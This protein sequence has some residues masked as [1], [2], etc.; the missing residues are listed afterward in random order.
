MD[1]SVER[2]YSKGDE[3]VADAARASFD[4]TADGYTPEQNARLLNFLAKAEPPHWTP[5]GH[6]RITIDMPKR[7]LNHE[8]ILENETL[9]AGLAIER[10]SNTD[11]RVTHSV[12]G[13]ANMVRNN[14]LGDHTQKVTDRLNS[15]KGLNQTLEVLGLRR[16]PELASGASYS[17]DDISLRIRCPIV[18]ARQLFKHQVGFV[19][20]EASGRYITYSTINRPWTWK[21]APDNKKQ[22]AGEPV[23]FLRHMAAEA[24]TSFAYGVSR[25]AYWFLRRGLGIA[26]E[27]AR[28]VMPLATD[29]TFVVTA[30]R[31]GWQR[32]LDH[33]L[34]SAAQS[35]IQYLAYAIGDEIH[36]FR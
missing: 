29:T 25:A 13:W 21:N 22:G 6:V 11:C 26:P 34:D 32:L 3:L 2:V 19:Y 24:V 36:E 1:I 31:E 33:R 10:L 16:E 5:F 14:A 12:W 15:L 18:I 7:W 23:G 17:D 27:Q 28:F 30:S 4:R 9:R 35:E 8:V 20:S